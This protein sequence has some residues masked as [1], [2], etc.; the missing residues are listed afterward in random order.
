MRGSLG[1]ANIVLF[2]CWELRT[3][4]I[5][6]PKKDASPKEEA[7]MSALSNRLGASKTRLSVWVRRGVSTVGHQR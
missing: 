1:D 3:W 5:N 4:E 7:L 2:Y 6:E